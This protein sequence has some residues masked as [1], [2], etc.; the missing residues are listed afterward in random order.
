MCEKP[1][2][3]S[4]LEKALEEACG[5]RVPLQ[6][7]TN[8]RVDPVEVKT[9]PRPSRRQ[10]QMEIAAQPFVQKA[11]ELFDGD[12]ARLRYVPPEEGP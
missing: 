9:P 6:M 4:R 3:R 1:N 10:Q 7:V 8:T 2:N 12:P 5:Q 11:M